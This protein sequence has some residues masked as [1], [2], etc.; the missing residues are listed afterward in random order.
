LGEAGYVE[1]RNVAIEYRW[2][3]GQ[4]DR[5]PELAADLV[6]RQVAVIVATGGPGPALAAK[7]ATG[8]IAI[9]FTGGGDPVRHGLVA[10]LARPGGNATG[11]TNMA[12]DLE[13]KRV[14]LL[15]EMVTT[16]VGIG[17]LVNPNFPDSE[18]QSTQVDK[19]AL[20]LRL[21]VL[22]QTATTEGEIDVAFATL[23]KQRIGALFVASDALFL[24]RREKLAAL[25]A[26]YAL[27]TI[28]PFREF[29]LAG[30]LISYGASIADGYRQAG[31]YAGRILKGEK[32]A[33]LPVRQP[34][35]FEL[36]INI[37]TA[38]ALGLTI[39]QSILLR[40]D[41]VIE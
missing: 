6:H 1:G 17:M 14:E 27:P 32:P 4:Y 21:Q 29:V 18:A 19:A 13:A 16:A 30:G 23:T 40:A 34:T 31:I 26:R 36:V 20:A 7:A 25:A 24:T 37:K 3:E 5:L 2:A 10:N 41:E 11:V 8:T 38:K 39:P 15:H 22:T 12:A 28:Y 33:D 9:V 35:K